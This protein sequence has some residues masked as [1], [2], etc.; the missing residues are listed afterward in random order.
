M[1]S[2]KQSLFSTYP[3]LTIHIFKILQRKANGKDLTKHKLEASPRISFLAILGQSKTLHQDPIFMV[4][5]NKLHFAC[6]SFHVS[7][8]S[9]YCLHNLRAYEKSV[10]N[11]S[12]YCLHNLR[13]YKKSILCIF[14][15]ANC[16]SRW[17]IHSHCHLNLIS[18]SQL[19]HIPIGLGIVQPSWQGKKCLF[20]RAKLFLS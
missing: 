2:I 18:K 11:L 5:S 13:A 20:K 6:Y 3:W 9:N 17:S 12:N 19:W 1:T 15:F 8:L 14:L 16:T 10:S 7:N 4:I